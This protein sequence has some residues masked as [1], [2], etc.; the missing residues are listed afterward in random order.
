MSPKYSSISKRGCKQMKTELLLNFLFLSV[1]QVLLNRVRIFFTRFFQTSYF[2][3]ECLQ[4]FTLHTYIKLFHKNTSFF[5][6]KQAGVSLACIS[7]TI[8]AHSSL[9]NLSTFDVLWHGPWSLV[10]PTD[11]QWD[12]I[13]RCFPLWWGSQFQAHWSIPTA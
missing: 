1:S 4:Y 13:N 3:F 11:L 7:W 9:P 2:Y 10:H 6:V 8:P 12:P 5:A